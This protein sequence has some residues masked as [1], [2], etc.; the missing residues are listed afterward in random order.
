MR[1][2]AGYG[3]H[4]FIRD[5]RSRAAHALVHEDALYEALE[6]GLGLPDNV[7]VTGVHFDFLSNHWAVLLVGEDFLEC[8]EGVQSPQVQLIQSETRIIQ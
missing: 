3:R 8:A 4:Q 7:A 2:K 1:I 5:Y 6:R